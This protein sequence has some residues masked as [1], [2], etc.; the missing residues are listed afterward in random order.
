M[1]SLIYVYSSYSTVCSFS[2]AICVFHPPIS[3][4]KL[5]KLEVC[6][7]T[8]LISLRK[9]T[10]DSHQAHLTE[11][12]LLRLKS[13]GSSGLFS[14]TFSISSMTSGVSF[15]ASLTAFTLS[16]IWCVLVAPRMTCP[17]LAAFELCDHGRKTHRADV[18]VLDT[19]S[20]AQLTNVTSKLL[21]NLREL[22]RV[23]TVHFA[24]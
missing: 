24:S 2:C 9:L 15:S 1:A 16:S 19:P 3:T 10:E 4:V 11:A 13:D 14:S 17:R 5:S 20:D 12:H 18:G 22:D 8:D 6:Y 23:S 7:T 21:S